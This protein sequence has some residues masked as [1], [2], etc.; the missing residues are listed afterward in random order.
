[1]KRR[2]SSVKRR[3]PNRDFDLDPRKLKRRRM[4][5]GLT[6]DELA[7]KV[8]C[9]RGHLSMLENDRH[10]PSVLLARSLAAE[11]GCDVRDLL[12]DERASGAVA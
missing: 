1:M 4:E 11:L 5:A 6:L 2:R 9:T 12:R 7:T 10:G 8:G 3:Y